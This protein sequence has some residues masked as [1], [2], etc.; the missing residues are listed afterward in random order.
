MLDIIISDDSSEDR[1]FSVIREMVGGYCGPHG[2]RIG[3]TAH[4]LGIDHFE[5]LQL[6]AKSELLITAH[7]DDV[8]YPK[9][10]RRII[11]TFHRVGA[12]VIS[13]NAILIDQH[14]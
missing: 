4:N 8:A 5:R 7:G 1:T 2:V 6:V 12:S 13:S 9:R 10:A 3:Q 11:D 14:V